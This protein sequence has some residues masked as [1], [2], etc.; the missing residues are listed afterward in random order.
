MNKRQ[1]KDL[2]NNWNNFS[3]STNLTLLQNFISPTVTRIAINPQCIIVK[4]RIAFLFMYLSSL[5]MVL[6]VI[7]YFSLSALP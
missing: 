4:E 3:L 2:I 6:I 5:Q 1:Y 7:N